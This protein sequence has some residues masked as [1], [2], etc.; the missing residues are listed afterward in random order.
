MEKRRRTMSWIL[1]QLRKSKDDRGMMANLRCVLVESKKHRAWPVLS[2]LG[3]AI[4]DDVTT[5]IAGLYA[6]HPEETPSGNLGVTCKAIEQK[7][8]DRR[9][10]DSRLTA[11]ERRFQHLLSAEKGVELWNRILRIVLM[12]KSQNVPINY[13]QLQTDVRFWNDRTRTEWATA[14]WAKGGEP[15]SEEAAV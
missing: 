13:L 3:V 12:A 7:R 11:T 9:S 4:D 8:G 1:E 15:T 10:E 6:T 14:F 5:Y 2:R